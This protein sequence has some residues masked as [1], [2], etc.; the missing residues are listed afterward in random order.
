MPS[1]GYYPF[2]KEIDMPR[3]LFA[4]AAVVLFG[5]AAY[6][7]QPTRDLKKEQV[8][9][10]KLAEVAPGAVETFQRATAAMD[11]RDYPQAVELYREVV[12]Q[13]PTFSPALRR[14][15]FSL[16]GL[17]QTDEGLA[18]VEN[19]LKIERSPENL[20][21]LA[22]LLAFPTEKKQ[23][24]PEQKEKALALAKEA[25]ERNQGLDDA[26]Y[27]ILMAQIALDLNREA[28]FRQATELLVRNHPEQMATHYFNAVRAAMDESWIAAEDE[29]KKAERLG[30]PAASAQAFLASGIHTRATA[31]R[32]VYTGSTSFPP[33]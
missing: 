22:E 32:W 7:Q 8:I 19:A 24:T 15:G 11:N 25:N 16:A 14:L 1:A 26:S 29:I 10:E 30:L 5:A 6:G 3:F 33:G 23:G 13:A 18:L 17:G 4:L 9:C 2:V 31:W 28:E 21:S 27:A 12:K 20:I